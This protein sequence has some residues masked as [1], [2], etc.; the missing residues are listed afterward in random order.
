MVP[1]AV[2]RDQN[3]WPEHPTGVTPR[4]T[5]LARNRYQRH[6]RLGA[7][8]EDVHG[9]EKVPISPL[10]VGL[11]ERCIQMANITTALVFAQGLRRGKFLDFAGG[12]G[13]LTLDAGPRPRLPP[14]QSP[15]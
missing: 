3:R 6:E 12:Y 5:P 14:S 8:G 11:L 13:T 15:L 10:G 7:D 1:A 9:H 2:V 4:R